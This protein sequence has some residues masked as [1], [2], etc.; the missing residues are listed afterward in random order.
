MEKRLLLYFLPA[1]FLL[2]VIAV[3]IVVPQYHGEGAT[4]WPKSYVS[5]WERREFVYYPLPNGCYRVKV[6][7]VAGGAGGSDAGEGVPEP[8]KV[9]PAIEVTRTMPPDSLPPEA[10]LSDAELAALVDFL[11]REAGLGDYLGRLMASYRCVVEYY[12]SAGSRLYYVVTLAFHSYPGQIQGASKSVLVPFWIEWTGYLK[13]EK[14]SVKGYVT[15]V[16]FEAYRDGGEWRLYKWYPR[17]SVGIP[18]PGPVQDPSIAGEALMAERIAREWLRNKGVEG[19]MVRFANMIE[20][21]HSRIANVVAVDCRSPEDW[22]LWK[23]VVD[24]NAGR[25]LE[26]E[27]RVAYYWGPPWRCSP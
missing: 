22:T 2:L 11:V 4:R 24:L 12:V 17:V 6:V 18:P 10:L 3:L 14:V 21:G 9:T 25:V 8:P 20:T 26:G 23:V 5:G 15:G 1:A 19:A 16:T 27:S 7:E 13:G